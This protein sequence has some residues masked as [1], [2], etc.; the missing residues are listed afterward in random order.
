MYGDGSQSRCFA[1]VKDVVRILAGLAELPAAVGEIVNVGTDAEISIAALAQQVKTQTGSA[2][3]IVFVPYNVAYGHDFEDMQRRV[4]DLA[5]LDRLLA[6]R[7]RT[8][9]DQILSAVIAHARAA[10]T[11]TKPHAADPAARLPAAAGR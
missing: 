8:G 4:P 2:S 10:G 1:Y 7:P 3:E 11:G 5:K 6:D 9:L